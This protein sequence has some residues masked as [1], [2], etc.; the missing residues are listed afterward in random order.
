MIPLDTEHWAR[1]VDLALLEI[2]YMQKPY[3]ISV[4]NNASAYPLNQQL[5]SC[6]SLVITNKPASTSVLPGNGPTAHFRFYKVKVL[7]LTWQK[8]STAQVIAF[9]GSQQRYI[10]GRS[11]GAETGKA[12]LPRR[13]GRRAGGC[14]SRCRGQRAGR[15]DGFLMTSL[16]LWAVVALATLPPRLFLFLLFITFHLHLLALFLLAKIC[17]LFCFSLF[18]LCLP[19]NLRMHQPPTVFVHLMVS[20]NTNDW[21]R[22]FI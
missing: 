9:S 20:A 11:L 16:V 2:L 21:K 13:E 19:P 7:P 1:C 8:K 22:Q 4:L 17:L 6:K 12:A 18:W 15:P 3:T 10:G 14:V 5:K